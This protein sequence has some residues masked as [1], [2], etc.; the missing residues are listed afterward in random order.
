[1]IINLQFPA[2]EDPMT[3]S[4]YAAGEFCVAQRV[5]FKRCSADS[6]FV[7]GG[8]FVTMEHDSGGWR[9][10]AVR[11]EGRNRPSSATCGGP[12]GVMSES[13][14]PA[15]LPRIMGDCRF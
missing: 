8:V 2:N 3:D 10:P 9:F 15:S 4:L 7:L 1:M 6:I 11:D 5:E 14:A 12:T 13:Q